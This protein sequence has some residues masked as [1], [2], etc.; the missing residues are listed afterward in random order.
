MPTDRGADP[1]LKIARRLLQQRRIEDAIALIQ[2]VRSA[3]P[4]QKAAVELLGMAQFMSRQFEEARQTFDLLVRMAPKDATAWVNL[5]AVQNVLKDHQASVK[6]LRNAIKRDKKSA[7][8]LLQ[9]GDRPEGHEDEFHGD[10]F[11]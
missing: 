3:E 4:D 11:L 5:G 10:Y 1:P 6:S 7:S 2:E 9:H 8:R